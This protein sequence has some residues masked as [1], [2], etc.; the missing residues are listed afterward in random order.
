MPEGKNESVNPRKAT[1]RRSRESPVFAS[2]RL[3]GVGA[4]VER[5]CGE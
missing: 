1:S 3:E 4:F 2:R 5:C